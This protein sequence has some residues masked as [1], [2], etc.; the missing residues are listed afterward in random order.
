M[1]NFMQACR[2]TFDFMEEDKTYLVEPHA[3]DA[4]RAEIVQR[5]WYWN[6]GWNRANYDFR[7]LGTQLFFQKN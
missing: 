2:A 3:W 4:M 5:G 6:E 1:Q 7:K